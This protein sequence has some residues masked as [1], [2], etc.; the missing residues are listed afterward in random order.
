MTRIRKAAVFA[1]ML[2]M[3]LAGAVQAQVMQQVPSDA[4]LVLKVNNLKQTN[5]KVI[6]F[7]N[8]LGIPAMPMP[9]EALTV[10]KDPLAALQKET[11][12]QQGLNLAGELA[13]VFCDPAT[14]AG[15]PEKAALIL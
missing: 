4:L 11:G 8:E 2:A 6:K 10:V 1:L 9:E 12:M 7:T 14:V 5:E 15:N 13:I 3:L